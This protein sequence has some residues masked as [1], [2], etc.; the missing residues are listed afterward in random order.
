[1]RQ[2]VEGGEEGVRQGVEILVADGGQVDQPHAAV[3]RLRGCALAAVDGDL[4]AA[5]GQPGGEFFG[6]GFESAVVGRNAARAEEGNAHAGGSYS[7]RRRGGRGGS[8][9]KKPRFVFSALPQRSPRLRGENKPD[10][11]C[12]TP[13]RLPS[14]RA[15]APFSW[16]P[17]CSPE[18]IGTSSPC[19]RGPRAGAIGSGGAWP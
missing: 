8:A 14:A 12:S 9:E 11:I 5:R 18:R 4:V 10:S 7:P 19:R 2:Q 6:K 13:S 3:H 15:C 1:M 17:A 16:A